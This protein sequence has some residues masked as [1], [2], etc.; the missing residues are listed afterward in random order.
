MTSS[1][2]VLIYTRFWISNMVNGGNMHVFF[3][4]AIDEEKSSL[5]ILGD[6]ELLYPLY[7]WH[8]V[9]QE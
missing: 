1:A 8:P 9:P 6:T 5:H 3:T 4:R 2:R 7:F